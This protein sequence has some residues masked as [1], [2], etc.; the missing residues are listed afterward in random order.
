MVRESGFYSQIN[1][2][3]LENCKA[4]SMGDDFEKIDAVILIAQLWDLK[5]K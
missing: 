2:K 3:V 1:V 5:I 4:V